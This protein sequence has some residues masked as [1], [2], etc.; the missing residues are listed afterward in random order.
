MLSVLSFLDTE[1]SCIV[2]RVDAHAINA[3][4]THCCAGQQQALGSE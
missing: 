4:V 1:V 3:G 2:A